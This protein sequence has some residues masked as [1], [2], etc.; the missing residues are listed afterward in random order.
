MAVGPAP[1]HAVG[2][3][4]RQSDPAIP[5]EPAL[6]L[7]CQLAD[8]LHRPESL[9]H[10]DTG[11]ALS[12]DLGDGIEPAH[13]DLRAGTEEAASGKKDPNRVRLCLCISRHTRLVGKSLGT[14]DPT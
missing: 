6:P 10:Q 12:T 2:I 7:S 8:S 5:E 11:Q 13:F 14:Q 4:V 3:R 1:I 9:F